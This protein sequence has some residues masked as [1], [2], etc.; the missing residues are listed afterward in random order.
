MG[1]KNNKPSAF[2][3]NHFAKI[4]AFKF[5]I[6]EE[7][8]MEK[9]WGDN[10]YDPKTKEWTTKNTGSGSCKRG[11][12]QHG[13]PNDLLDMMILHLP[14]PCTAK[15]YRVE[16][17][18]EDPSDDV[19][20]NAI[21]NCDPN[22]LLMFYVSK[23]IP[24]S[25]ESGRFF[26]FGHVFSGKV[27]PS[28]KVRI[29]GP[30][31]VPY[32]T[33]DLNVRGVQRTLVWMGQTQV[34]LLDVPSRNTVALIGLDL[35]VTKNAILTNC[36]KSSLMFSILQQRPVF[37]KMPQRDTVSYNALVFG[38][39]S[40]GNMGMARMIHVRDVVL[41]NSLLRGSAT[42]DMHAKCRKLEKSVRFFDDMSVKNWVSW[43]A[44]IAGVFSACAAIK[45]YTIGVQLHWLTIKGMLQSNVCVENAI[46]DM[47]GKCGAL[48]EAR[49]VFE[50]M[51]IRDAV[52]W[53]AIIVAY[54]QNGNVDETLHLLVWMLCSGLES[55]EFTFGSVLKACAGLQSLKDGR[56]SL[57]EQ[58][59]VA[60][61]FFSQ[62]LEVGAK[63]DNFTFATV[64]DTCANLATVSLRR[65]IHG[66]I[67]KQEMQSDVFINMHDSRF[68]F[69]KSQNKDFGTRNAM[70]SGYANHG[71]GLD[72][73]RIFEL[74]KVNNV[75]PNHAFSNIQHH[76]SN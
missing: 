30:N 9:L 40:I 76:L 42:V 75:K 35:F 7:N 56:F 29:M 65:Q 12:V 46:L 5:R 57:Q 66:Q 49:L 21:R 14:L 32:E 25:N 48:A 13:S 51:Q 23:M 45:S 71:F 41:W 50:E 36:G 58:S 19:Y 63:P 60:Q 26:A 4:Y 67:I 11:F 68:I 17:L 44:L 31:Y 1:H 37:D 39:A 15:K 18:Y 55:D 24:A 34:T 27:S 10:F 53:N 70:I 61:K 73:I 64:L 38:Y 59:E 47:Y 28:M 33:R 16:N 69:E 62:M 74:M 8:M 43:S 52:S 20:A 3:L 54:E 6:D 72:A 2:T 22:G